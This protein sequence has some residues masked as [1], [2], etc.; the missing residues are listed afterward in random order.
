MGSTTY[1]ANGSLYETNPVKRWWAEKKPILWAWL[2]KYIGGLEDKPDPDPIT[3][4][5]IL[6]TWKGMDSLN[7]NLSFTFFEDNTY[8]SERKPSARKGPSAG[9]YK[10]EGTTLSGVSSDAKGTFSA[11]RFG[12]EMSGEWELFGYRADFT[13]N[14]E[15]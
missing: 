11:K 4:K 7:G 14:K 6:G 8:I 2:T 1:Y 9:N 10:I 5:D 12:Q 3:K 15:N 13:L